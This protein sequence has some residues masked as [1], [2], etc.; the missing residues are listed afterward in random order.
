VVSPTDQDVVISFGPV[1]TVPNGSV[2]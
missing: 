2:E 1:S